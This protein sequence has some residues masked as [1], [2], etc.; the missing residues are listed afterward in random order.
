M[1]PEGACPCCVPV[2]MPALVANLPAFQERLGACAAHHGIEPSRAEGLLLAFEEVFVNIC[3]YAF[4]QGVGEVTLT[5]FADGESFTAEIANRGAPFDFASL[6]DPD[7]TG[8]LDARPLGGLGW[9]LIRH[10]VEEV[11]CCR[12]EGCNIVSLVLHRHRGEGA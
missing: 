11:H 5:C 2:T 7:L 10:A 4:P 9:F 8:D 3:R 12:R 1:A 6:P